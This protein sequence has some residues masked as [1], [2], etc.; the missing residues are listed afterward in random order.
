MRN[1][2]YGYEMKDGKLVAKPEEAKVVKLTYTL[3]GFGLNEQD[4][5]HLLDQ[6]VPKETKEGYNLDDHLHDIYLSAYKLK[7]FNAIGEVEEAF[8]SVHASLPDEQQTELRNK[9]DELMNAIQ[10]IVK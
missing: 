3:S 9:T 5:T 4:I 1:V 10:K 7:L 2:P 8:E 6:H